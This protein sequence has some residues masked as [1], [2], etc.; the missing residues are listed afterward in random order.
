MKSKLLYYIKEIIIFIIILF[1]IS[2][3]VS[4]YK[5]R[6]LDNTQ[7]N[8]RNITLID[9]TKYSFSTKKPTLVHIW[10]TWCPTCKL[11]AS[12]IQTISEH[13][14][15]LTIAFKSG[16]DDDIQNYLDQNAYKF[17]VVND[18]SGFITSHF[19][20]EV[21]P[22]TL[23]YNK[24]KKLIFSDVGYTSTLSLYLKMLWAEI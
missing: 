10:A 4:L 17:S 21:F 8:L 7:L 11:E 3:A 9:T 19:N 22:T 2:N 23:I 24:D 12:N 5:S 1:V 14:N 20:V 13:F 16:S 15:V 18:E 6:H